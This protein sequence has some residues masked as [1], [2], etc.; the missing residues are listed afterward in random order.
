MNILLRKSSLPI[1]AA[2]VALAALFSFGSAESTPT[3]TAATN[4][5]AKVSV[6]H[7]A[8]FAADVDST[9]VTVRVDGVDALTNF[10]Y[11]QI[12]NDVMLTAGD[13]QVQILAG[14]SVA[15]SETITVEADKE[16]TLAA[17][18]GANSNDLMLMPFVKD[19]TPPAGTNGKVFVAHLAPF[20]DN[21]DATKVDICTDAG[22]PVTGLTGVPYKGFTNPYLTLPVGDY[23][24]MITV[25]GSNCETVALDLPAI[26]LTNGEIID[27]FA[28]GLLN[29]AFPLSVATTTGILRS[30]L[31]FVGR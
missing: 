20:S 24:L 2:V 6:A 22:T 14:G 9:A 1:V 28:I 26:R 25:A 13:H 29:E 23:D 27:V 31:P 30:F 16:Y 7:F 15:I 10:K 18:G 17:I 11:G 5:D 12:Q 8:P 19:T 3:A 21:L 4:A